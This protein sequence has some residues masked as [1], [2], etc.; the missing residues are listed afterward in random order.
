M[1]IHGVAQ[2]PDKPITQALFSARIRPP[3]PTFLGLRKELQSVLTL[4]PP[5]GGLINLRILSWCGS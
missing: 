4:R 5:Q 2:K 3:M 1:Y